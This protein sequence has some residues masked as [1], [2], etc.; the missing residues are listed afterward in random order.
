[1]FGSQTRYAFFAS[2]YPYHPTPSN[3]FNVLP[4]K[5][6][7]LRKLNCPRALHPA[8]LSLMSKPFLDKPSKP[9]MFLSSP[10][11]LPSNKMPK[12]WSK[13]RL[14]FTFPQRPFPPFWRTNL[15]Q[16]LHFRTDPHQASV[17]LVSIRCRKRRSRLI[18]NPY[19]RLTMRPSFTPH[20]HASQC[21]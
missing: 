21:Y 3:P 14:V 11:V 7:H 4:L 17:S 5:M 18:F 8:F 9:I 2:P 20:I 13:H 15:P 19:F 1:M 16:S 6:T 12:P 10:I